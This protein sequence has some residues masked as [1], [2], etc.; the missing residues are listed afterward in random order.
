MAGINEIR[1]IAGA[2]GLVILLLLYFLP[3]IIAWKKRNRIAIFALNLLAGW[4]LVGWIAA[5]IWALSSEAQVP[6]GALQQVATGSLQPAWLCAH[7]GKYSAV[8]S[9]FCSS[10]GAQFP[11]G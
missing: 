3:T 7:C 9:R 5:L 6:Q 11:L 1:V 2:L 4:T 8:G 10:C